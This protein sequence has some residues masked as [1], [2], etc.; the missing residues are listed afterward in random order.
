MLLRAVNIAGGGATVSV[1]VTPRTVPGP[2]TALSA[3]PGSTTAVL[4]YQAPADTGGSAITGYQVSIDG[5]TTWTSAGTTGTAPLTTTIGGLTSGTAYR[6]TVRATN[7][8]G[9]G[10]AA[11]PVSV[12]HGAPPLQPTA[13]TATA[14]T[15]S[16]VAGT[17]V[18][19][20]GR[21][22]AGWTSG[23]R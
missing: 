18:S 15:S 5:G 2:P 8:A 20:A 4:T 13:V 19:G 3:T 21:R 23:R 10:A 6:I 1:T 11:P 7:G 17:C 16:I 12:T 14:G 9:N 22:R